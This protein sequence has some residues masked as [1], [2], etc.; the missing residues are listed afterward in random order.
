MEEQKP[1]SL[2]G[3]SP[4][5]IY[6]TVSSGRRGAARREWA[7]PKPSRDLTPSSYSTQSQHE[8]SASWTIEGTP[9]IQGHV[10]LAS[11]CLSLH[12]LVLPRR[13]QEAKLPLP[14]QY[15]S[16]CRPRHTQT[17][18]MDPRRAFPF[19]LTGD[20]R[21]GHGSERRHT[22]LFPP[23]FPWRRVRAWNCPP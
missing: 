18:V 22:G 17:S 14:V 1:W 10:E 11:T 9:S 3:R 12:L 19:L 21:T 23:T 6:I 16:A 4:V 15:H 2:F 5:R 20:G 7:S 13:S 8:T